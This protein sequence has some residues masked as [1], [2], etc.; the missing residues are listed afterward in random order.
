MYLV[1]LLKFAWNTVI[2][3]L[4]TKHIQPEYWVNDEKEPQYKKA[5]FQLPTLEDLNTYKLSKKE[6]QLQV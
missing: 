3:W 4:K 6:T 1:L 2:I 5:I